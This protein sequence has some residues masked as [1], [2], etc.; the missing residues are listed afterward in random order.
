M[1]GRTSPLRP[2][3][4][5]VRITVGNN[6]PLAAI[7]SPGDGTKYRVGDAI[8]FAGRG[9]RAGQ[10][11]PA[12]ELAWELRNAHNEHVHY[13]S[14]PSQAAGNDPNPSVGS[15]QVDDHGD[16]A[17]YEL[18]LTAT[19]EGTLTDVQCVELRPR[20][21]TYAVGTRTPGPDHQL[22]GRG[23]G[24][25]RSGGDR[26][27][28]GISTDADRACDAAWPHLRPLGRRLN[29]PLAGVRDG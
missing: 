8:A 10:P 21:T 24:A 23:N 6:P 29:Q 7:L 4:T 14:G 9:T 1:T 3:T 11:L 19:V 2:E 28:P 16:D 17:R 22:Q 25:R 13:S 18:C 15:F 12:R 20:K 5:S 27:D 26:A